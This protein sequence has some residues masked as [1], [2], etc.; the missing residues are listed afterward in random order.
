MT[1][2]GAVQGSAEA[3]SPGA[4]ASRRP[5]ALVAA[6]ILLSR[7]MGLA[8]QKVFS[9]Y[10]GAADESDAFT[11]AFRIP[12]ILQNLFGEGVLSASFIPVY[13]Q[14]RARGDDQGRQELAG[15][16]LGVLA[17]LSSVV[18][19]L[20]VL[21]APLLVQ[22]I[23]PGFQGEKRELTIHL[24]R[25]LFPGAGL[26]VLAAWCLGVLNSHGK[27]F[28]SYAAPVLWNLCMMAAMVG[29]GGR[30]TLP[31]LAA[32]LAWGSV[33][34]SALQLAVQW[35]NVS[36]VL[37]AW[38]VTVSVRSPHVRTVLHNFAPVFVG[39]GVTQLS[40]YID[41]FIASFLVAGAA[42]ILNNVQLL[43]MLPV[44]LFGMS[45]QAAELPAMSSVTGE[46]EEVAA[47]LRERLG[48]GLRRIAFFIVP[49]AVAFLA[50]GDL[51]ARVVFEGG[52]F[53]VR[54]VQW[55]WGVLAGSAVG[56]LA[57]TLGRLYASA[58]YALRDTRTPLRF[59]MVRVGLTTALGLLGSLWLP[60]VL[61][62]DPRWAV[63]GLTA[64]AG[65][66]AWVEFALLRRAVGRRIGAVSIPRVTVLTLWGC[67]LVAA[68]LGWGAR[69]LMQGLPPLV[70]SLLVLGT[71]SAG[72]GVATFVARIPQSRAIAARLGVGA[73]REPRGD[74]A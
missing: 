48:L 44:S 47:R 6:G 26:L 11:Q 64:S 38:R 68:S 56:L 31:R 21:A 28:L 13:A 71:Y 33:A 24:V 29:W 18:V 60:R 57:S 34:G 17:F 52:E 41:S 39:R 69:L 25:I 7:L 54:Q 50:F 72:Y 20:G 19:L 70:A 49:S 62:L 1:Q 58:L 59:A 74:D 4:S 12:N 8:R 63:S 65:C 3:S 16:V 35:R 61:G 55:V 51:L 66:A 2:P 36:R 40:A 22:L 43:Y 27:F 14:L 73:G 10:F 9:F 5:A 32:I 37:G 46:G 15:A 23:A 42:T 67:A 53:G 30:V 45:I